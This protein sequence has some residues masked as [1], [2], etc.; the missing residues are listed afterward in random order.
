MLA[1]FGA[2]PKQ[3]V[4]VSKCQDWPHRTPITLNPD[5]AAQP[6]MPSHVTSRHGAILDPRP[7][8]RSTSSADGV[9]ISLKALKA[10]VGHGDPCPLAPFSVQQLLSFESYPCGFVGNVLTRGDWAPPQA[11]E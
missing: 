11:R 7:L 1:G 4:T 6:R 3:V 8:E 5:V 10:S 2:D 9:A